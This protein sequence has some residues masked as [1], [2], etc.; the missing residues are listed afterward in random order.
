MIC[1]VAYYVADSKIV[2]SKKFGATTLGRMTITIMVINII[3]KLQSAVV[4]MY[5]Y[6]SLL[7][8]KFQKVTKLVQWHLVEWQLPQWQSVLLVNRDTQWYIFVVDLNIYV[9]DSKIVKSNKVGVPTLCRMTIILMV[10]IIMGKMELAVVT[11][12]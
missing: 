7:I 9:A 3:G 2:K 11:Y 10:I 12:L 8:L 6:S 4:H 5:S 1:S